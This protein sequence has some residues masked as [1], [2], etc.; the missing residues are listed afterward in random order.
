[1][2]F[3]GRGQVVYLRQT[4]GTKFYV[5]PRTLV[6]VPNQR[7]SPL[8]VLTSKQVTLNWPFTLGNGWEIRESSFISWTKTRTYHWVEHYI[9]GLEVDLATHSVNCFKGKCITNAKQSAHKGMRE[10]THFLRLRTPSI[11]VSWSFLGRYKWTPCWY[12]KGEYLR[13]LYPLKK[14]CIEAI[15]VKMV[16]YSACWDFPRSVCR[17][18]KYSL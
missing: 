12:S 13:L 15:K 2:E 5:A 16:L 1:M 7:Y 11:P 14:N 8:L 10:P 3:H 6:C 4:E 9:L 18:V 17:A